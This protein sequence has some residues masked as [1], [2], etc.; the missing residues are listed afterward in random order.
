MNVVQKVFDTEKEKKKELQKA[1]KKCLKEKVFTFVGGA[2]DEDDM[3]ILLTE[4][5]L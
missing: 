4:C 5:T 1:I 3:E 2:A